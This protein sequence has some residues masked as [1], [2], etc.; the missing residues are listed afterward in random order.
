MDPG[1]NVFLADGFY[2]DVL[3]SCGFHIPPWVE[4]ES[5]LNFKKTPLINQNGKENI[6]LILFN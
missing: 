6:T 5:V 4:S 1:D 3:C 2:F